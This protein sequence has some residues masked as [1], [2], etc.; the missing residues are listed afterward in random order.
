VLA[1]SKRSIPAG[2]ATVT[3]VPS[4]NGEDATAPGSNNG[5]D[6]QGRQ[7]QMPLAVMNCFASRILT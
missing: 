5:G 6:G 4:G 1:K 2:E 7:K 3:P